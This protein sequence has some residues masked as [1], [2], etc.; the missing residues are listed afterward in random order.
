MR[1][2]ITKKFTLIGTGAA[3]LCSIIVFFVLQ[4]SASKQMEVS[5]SS[6]TEVLAE[7]F[8][9]SNISAEN[10]EI[11]YNDDLRVTW[12]AQNGDILFD[13][14][15]ATENHADRPEFISALQTGTGQV[16]R[17]SDTLRQETFYYAQK[18]NDGSVLRVS[19]TTQS[20]WSHVLSVLPLILLAIFAVAIL[21]RI[22]SGAFTRQIMKPIESINISKPLENDVY[23]EFTPLLRRINNQNEELSSQLIQ[24]ESMRNDI[25]AI[26]NTMIEGLILLNNSGLV[27]SVNPSACKILE[28]SEDTAIGQ[29]LLALNRNSVFMSLAN[30][31]EKNENLQT[32]F[33]MNGRIYR[34]MLS[35]AEEG[36][37][38]LMLVDETEKC[39]SEQI[40]REFSANV[41]HELKTPLQSILG[42]AELLKNNIVNEDDKN[43]FYTNIYKECRRLIK[44]VQDIIDLSRLD[45]GASAIAKENVD[46]YNTALLVKEELV[47]KAAKKN[48]TINVTGKKQIVFGIPSLL[49]EIVSNL[50]DNAIAYNVD[51]GSVTINVAK[52]NKGVNLTVTD[53][54]IGIPE[55]HHARV[56][57]RFYRVDKSHSRVTGGTGLGLSIVKHAVAVHGGEISLQSKQG[58]GTSISINF[59]NKVN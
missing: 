30:A 59:N 18:L 48:I 22:A 13:T 47:E 9:N 51:G 52:T 3:F 4:L 20:V 2:H 57:E 40:R 35:K 10:I 16:R 29:P 54:G 26:M 17:T 6:S 42:Y 11:D 34:V 23:D 49:H 5:V 27:L 15:K 36:G 25:A 38:I 32:Q 58:H 45:E 43:S 28:V 8:N 41:S 50:A 1:K 7:I 37:S 19:A 14:A 21:S 24:V 55:Q 46:I 56:F 33:N 44:L 53:T 12:I 31:V 39:E